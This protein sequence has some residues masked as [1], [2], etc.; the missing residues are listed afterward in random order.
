M[1]ALYKGNSV[2]Y[3]LL[4]PLHISSTGFLSQM[5]WGLI[6]PVQ[7]PGVGL[8]DVGSQSLASSREVPDW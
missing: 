1:Q 2:P 5:L 8:P 6:S 4:G 3:S 7:I